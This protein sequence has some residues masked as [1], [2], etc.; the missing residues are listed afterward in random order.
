MGKTGN[1][2]HLRLETKIQHGKSMYSFLNALQQHKDRFLIMFR[3]VQV[4]LG[5]LGVVNMLKTTLTK[6][7]CDAEGINTC[8][9][10]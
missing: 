10:Q 5:V 3:H 7:E 6:A 4:V 8:T 2:V 9:N 1:N